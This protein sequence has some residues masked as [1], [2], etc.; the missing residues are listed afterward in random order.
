MTGSHAV[1]PGSPGANSILRS[2]A[3]N[4]SVTVGATNKDYAFQGLDFYPNSITIDAGDT[5]TFTVA[6]GAGGDAHTVAFVPDGAKMPSTLDPKDLQPH[7][8]T[9]VTGRKLL[10]SG[11]LV[12]GQTYTLKFAKPGTYRI[13]CL[14]HEPA[15]E[16][17]VVVQNAGTP[18]PHDAAYYRKLAAV[19]AREDVRGA[20]GSMRLFPFTPGGTSVAAGI[21]PGLVQFPPSDL[22]VLRFVD[23][24]DPTQEATSGNL[25]V[26]AN[27]IVT[28]VNETS[29]EPHTVT[30]NVAGKAGVPNIPPDPPVNIAPHGAVT[31]YDGSKVIN[32]GT[33]VGGRAFRV[34]FTK[35]GTYSYGCVYHFNSGMGGTITVTP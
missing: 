1:L 10:N 3:T 23:S 21:D 8:G 9:T 24:D 31:T 34:L 26:K 15:M 22:T 13:V 19:E 7:G 11:I 35:A 12:G 25:T 18:Y 29:N 4:W 28:F 20:R 17:A 14:F 6:G 30:L 32:S 33:L 5:V 27:S 16:G 2:H